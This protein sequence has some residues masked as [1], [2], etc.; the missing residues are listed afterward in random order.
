MPDTGPTGLFPVWCGS[1]K[2][3]EVGDY[4]RLEVWGLAR[5]LTRAIYASTAGFPGTERYG[6]ALQLRQAANSIGANIAEGI[7]RATDRDTLRFLSFAMGS[8]NEVE[9]H[10]V[11]AGD[12][13]LLAPSVARDLITQVQRVRRMLTGLRTTISTR[14][15]GA[16]PRS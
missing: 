16:A 5:N 2:E 12:V 13:G 15:D 3:T 10:L 11:V 14:A 8:A 7:G 6:L 9:Q 1:C 4:R